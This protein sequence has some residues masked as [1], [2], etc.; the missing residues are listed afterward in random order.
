MD[1]LRKINSLGKTNQRTLLRKFN[2]RN[3]NQA[4][5]HYTGVIK[6]KYTD[7]EKNN[8]YKL[9]RNE[10]NQ[11]IDE[12]RRRQPLVNAINA[13]RQ[14]IINVNRRQVLNQ[15]RRKNEAQNTIKRFIE[16]YHSNALTM[17]Q[18]IARVERF[19]NGKEEPF[20]LVLKSGIANVERKFKFNGLSHFKN[21]WD[22]VINS[23]EV[24][25]YDY[26]NTYK[27]QQ[28]LKNGDVSKLIDYVGNT[29]INR[30]L[31]NNGNNRISRFITDYYDRN[32]NTNKRRM[33]KEYSNGMKNVFDLSV[34]KTIAFVNG[35]C[36]NDSRYC[37]RT[38]K[39]AHF[40]YK[41]YNPTGRNNNCLFKCLE[42]ILGNN[43]NIKKLRKDFELPTNTPVSIVDAYK[44]IRSLTDKSIYII[45][46]EQ[47]EELDEDNTYIVLKD[48]HYYVVEEF[49]EI[50]RKDKKTKRGL[51]TFDFETR[52]TEDYYLIK[53]S[54]TKSYIL[55]DTI[56][57]IYY[58]P[59]DGGKVKHK[60][61][62]SLQNKDKNIERKKNA[63]ITDDK[64][65]SARKFI[66][67]LNEQSKIKKSYNI[68]AH[69]GGNFDFYFIISAM[70]EQELKDC[71][72][73]MRGTTIIS[74]NYKGNL[75]KDSYCFM[76][77]SLETLSN[78]FKVE[79][80]KLTTLTINDEEISSSQLCF[81]KNY[82]TFND[83]MNLQENEPAFW[84]K[85]IEYC[86]RDCIALYQIW[87][88]FTGCVNTL[89]S[90]I[91]PYLLQK[92]PLMSSSTI[93]SHSKKI[94]NTLN[95]TNKKYP[96]MG[97]DKRTMDMFMKDV[98]NKD[99]DMEKYKFITKFKRGGISHCHKAGLHTHGITS[100]DIASQYPASL[101]QSRIPVG[102]SHWTN[103]YEKGM[104]G[105]YHLKNL[106]FNTK[107]DLKPIAKLK[108][109][110]V[111]NWNTGE[112]VDDVFVDTYT[113]DYLQKYYGLERFDV[114]QGLISSEDIDGH[115]LFGKYV[116]TFYKEKKNQD[117]L[118]KKQDPSYNPALRETIKL[119]T[120]SLTGKLVEDPE[121]HYSLKF[122]IEN[123]GAD[124]ILNGVGVN[125]EF[126]PNKFNEWIIAGVMV[127]SYSKRLLFEYIRCLP[128]DSNSVIH[129][130]TDGIY[131]D[132]RDK[133]IFDKN[134]R[135]YN[136]EYKAIQYGDD[137]GNIKIETNTP[138]GNDDYFLGKKFYC[139]TNGD[140]DV[141]KNIIDKIKIKGIPKC[142]I[143]DAGNKIK[144]VD[145][146]V[147]R[148][149]YNGEKVKKE[150][151]TLKRDLF[152]KNTKISAYKAHRTINPNCVYKKWE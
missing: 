106:K 53:A 27:R 10:Y 129:I 95:A 63:F 62:Q 45:D 143:D 136:G 98:E 23:G 113:I 146:E 40:E 36:N 135:A 57:C 131:F 94:L 137:L 117:A 88:K 2:H 29:E 56:C 67:W 103:T 115:K 1:N 100:V 19:L 104:H 110:G 41:V 134:L 42:K 150:F 126:N 130:E 3:I 49:K 68:I 46:W 107:Y 55:K 123:D 80:G 43:V 44:I 71:D 78:N 76:T 147:Y 144:L 59:Y 125:K 96:F 8:A 22:K 24:L 33:L 60:Y 72:I 20:E 25:D 84:D 108:S 85:Y 109:S 124:A 5:K 17:E 51:L 75:F 9:M 127:Y 70:T 77:F 32:E 90:S 152:S 69:N 114:E 128:D 7:I 141:N 86:E 14:N 48:G 149:V 145:K 116:D 99:I 102:L 34:I 112:S 82:L 30:H 118:N 89:I 92:C 61:L 119:Y 58:K 81:Y 148:T 6:R 133:D 16:R 64:K 105:F 11:M 111:L 97:R 120:N 38:I 139:I 4:I 138:A 74:I 52:K 35:G 151:M 39:S 37:E 31:L 91:N 15:I 18:M 142:T 83:F 121:R 132:T 12:M 73:Q 87:E 122:A 21:Y 50:L 26:T 47:N 66:D 101:V 140:K 79:E 65:T 28:N 93:G 13:N 54:N